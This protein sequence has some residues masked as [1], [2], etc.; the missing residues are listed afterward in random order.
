MAAQKGGRN[1]T[2]F[3]L[4]EL[5]AATLRSG[6]MPRSG[7]GYNLI[8]AQEERVAVDTQFIVEND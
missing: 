5:R 1:E 2:G 3:N 7:L 4:S 6:A 8:V